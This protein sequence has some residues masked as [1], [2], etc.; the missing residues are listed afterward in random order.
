MGQDQF[1]PGIAEARLENGSLIA[2]TGTKGPGLS[3]NGTPGCMGR[4]WVKGPDEAGQGL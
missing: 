2:Q 3:L 1:G 4:M